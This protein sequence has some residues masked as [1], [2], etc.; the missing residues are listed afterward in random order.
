LKANPDV[1]ARFGERCP[2]E[3]PQ[4]ERADLPT[5][6]FA[7]G[8]AGVAI[9]V[10]KVSI[11]G[12][13]VTT[14]RSGRGSERKAMFSYLA[15]KV[16]TAEFASEPFRHILIENFF[17][18]DHFQK[19]ISESPVKVAEVTND[20]ELFSVLQANG[21]TPIHFPGTT[22]NVEEYVRWHASRSPKEHSNLDTCE[23]YGV[24]LRL[25]DT[26]NEFVKTVLGFLGSEAWLSALARRFEIDLRG[27]RVDYGLQKYLDG[28]EISPHP[29]KRQ[30]ALTYM[31][32]INPS[33]KSGDID[34][35]THYLR[36]RADKRY[37]QAFWEGNVSQDRCWVPW[38]WCET[39]KIQNRNNSIVVFSPGDDTMH[40]VRARYDHLPTQRTQ[41][42][43]NLWHGESN[44]TGMPS[45][46]DFVIGETK[47]RRAR[48]A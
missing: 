17:A 33:D 9:A 7:I 44:T 4:D 5:D 10:N 39:V 21:Y 35:H 27:K 16:L 11:G 12:E 42:Y 24:T 46:T 25:Q 19:L 37:V 36:F 45:W 13:V 43:G 48:D 30:K 15:D 8:V 40:A 28:Y 29:D 38:D 47:S 3:G 6:N 32:N 41:L 20:H 22:T 26:S 18:E 2:P 31:V 34:F 1:L 14:I 23:G